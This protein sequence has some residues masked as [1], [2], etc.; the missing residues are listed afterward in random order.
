MNSCSVL[1]H[2]D[3]RK[4]RAEILRRSGIA[5]EQDV[6]VGSAVE[7]LLVRRVAARG[8]EAELV[9][10]VKRYLAEPGPRFRA[11]GEILVGRQRM[12][13]VPAVASMLSSK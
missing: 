1:R 2:R 5:A 7:G 8:R 9:G 3:E 13:I 10:R 12:L 6:D 11:G 4:I